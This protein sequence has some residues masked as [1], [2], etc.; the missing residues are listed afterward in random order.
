MVIHFPPH[1]V[2]SRIDDHPPDPAHQQHFN[3][4][5]IPDLEPAEI[6]EHLQKTVMHYFHSLFIGVDIAES[7]LQAKSIILII[8]RLLALTILS[9]APCNYVEQ[10]FQI[11]LLALDE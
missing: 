2:D 11:I 8:Q 4:I 1:I 10:F 7:Y 6:A 3:L 9:C 5:L